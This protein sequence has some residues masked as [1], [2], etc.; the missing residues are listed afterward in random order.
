MNKEAKAGNEEINEYAAA[1]GSGRD[2][3]SAKRSL[4]YMKAV[5]MAQRGAMVQR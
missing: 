1:G 5:I 2:E 4:W 3:K